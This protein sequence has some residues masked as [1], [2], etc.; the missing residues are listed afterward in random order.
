M[1]TWRALWLSL[2]E[3]INF[4]LS[5]VEMQALSSQVGTYTVHTENSISFLNVS[6][7]CHLRYSGG[8]SYPWAPAC[9]GAKIPVFRKLNS[10]LEWHSC[11]LILQFSIYKP[12]S[13]LVLPSAARNRLVRGAVQQTSTQDELNNMDKPHISLHYNGMIVEWLW[14]IWMSWMPPLQSICASISF[15]KQRN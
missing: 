9:I 14:Q 15:C 7:R 2:P 8:L 6:S 4:L 3:L 1:G 5:V 13:E 10:N 12:I 11:E